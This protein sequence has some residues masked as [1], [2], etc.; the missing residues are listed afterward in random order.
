MPLGAGPFRTA[1][2]FSVSAEAFTFKRLSARIRHASRNPALRA[3]QVRDV[4]RLL[5]EQTSQLAS[6]TTLR[7]ELAGLRSELAGLRQKLVE[8]GA[9]SDAQLDATMEVTRIVELESGMEA[10]DQEI[11]AGPSLHELRSAS[12]RCPPCGIARFCEADGR[13]DRRG[14]RVIIEATTE[15]VDPLGQISPFRVHKQVGVTRSGSGGGLAGDEAG[16]PELRQGILG[17]QRRVRT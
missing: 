4:E 11:E 8:A 7:S 12:V 9:P 14:D 2:E 13:D 16:A 15:S 5:A 6:L 1:R 17:I 10:L 3:K